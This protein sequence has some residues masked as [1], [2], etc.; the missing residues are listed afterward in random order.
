MLKNK[1]ARAL[2]LELAS[3]GLCL[4]T[5]RVPATLPK[6]VAK[7]LWERVKANRAG[8]REVLVNRRDPDL[9]AVRRE[10]CAS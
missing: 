7:S 9:E 6:S 5:G 2:Y 1:T 4:R 3:H 10:G 8:L